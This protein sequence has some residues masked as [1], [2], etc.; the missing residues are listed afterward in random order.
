MNNELGLYSIEL[1]LG[2]KRSGKTLS[3]TAE[4]YIETRNTK[5]TVYA[6][7]HL[8]KK[9]FPN[10][11]FITYTELTN[12]FKNK[13]KFKNCVFL[14]DE[15]HIF[16]DSRSFMEKGNKKIGYFLGQMGKR[17]N[18]F[19][20]TSHFP[21]LV[22]YR[23]RSYCENWKF[24]T[25][26]LVE[27]NSYRPLLNYNRKL[28]IQEVNKLQIKIKSTIR[29]LQNFNFMY[30]DNGTRYIVAKKYFDMYDTEE[31]IYKGENEDEEE[32]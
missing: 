22:D 20:G 12:F 30:V 13:D 6:N 7:Y 4:T 28:S 29:K 26:G 21:E 32:N 3:M 31:L 2:E 17:G 1:Y 5:I 15:C 25:K 10:F 16:L 18:V 11:K 8:N 27:K 9:Y 24:I 19:R 23:L 14:I